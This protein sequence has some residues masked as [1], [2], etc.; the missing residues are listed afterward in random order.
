MPMTLRHG[1]TTQPVRV[2]VQILQSRFV[3]QGG[4]AADERPA[5]AT[6]LPISARRDSPKVCCF[7]AP[8]MSFWVLIAFS[9][10]A[11]SLAPICKG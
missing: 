7:L 3:A 9:P 11:R 10:L 1:Q 8:L 6:P 5:V 2:A 4:V